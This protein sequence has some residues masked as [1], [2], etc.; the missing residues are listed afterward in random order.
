[1]IEE[2]RIVST[3]E[4]KREIETQDDDLTRWTETVPNLFSSP[5]RDVGSFVSTIYSVTHFQDNIERKKLLKGGLNADPFVVATAALQDP[6]GTVVTLERHKP[7]AVRIP[8]LCE[9]FDIPCLNLE[10][11]MGEEGWV[12]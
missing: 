11:F 12:F 1:M 10:G 2:E 5:T 4:V 6:V 9:Y 7:N 8:N 3:R